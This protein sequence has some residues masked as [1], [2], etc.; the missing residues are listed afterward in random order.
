MK[1]YVD[2]ALDTGATDS[3]TGFT[4]FTNTIEALRIGSRRVSNS[5]NNWFDGKLDEIGVWKGR[6]LNS[7]EVSD[8]YNAGNGI[9]YD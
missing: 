4:G 7:T 5:S 1:I 3:G 2:G 8:I 6:V 9:S